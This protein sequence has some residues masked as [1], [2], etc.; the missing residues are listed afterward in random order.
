MRSWRSLRPRVVHITPLVLAS[1]AGAPAAADDDDQKLRDRKPPIIA[2]IARGP[3][4]WKLTTRLPDIGP[5]GP[6]DSTFPTRNMEL[7]SWLPLSSFPGYAGATQKSGADC[8]GYVSPSGRRYALIGLGWGTGVVEVTDPANPVILTVIPV[9]SNAYNSLW[10]DVTVIGHYAY[11][12]SD[13]VGVGIQVIDLSDVDT[14]TV[15]LVRNHSQGGHSRTHTILSNPAS[16]YLYLCGGNVAGSGMVPAATAPDPTLPTFDGPGW[17]DQYVHEAQ[18]VSYTS[19]PYAGKEIA[20][21]F[22]AGPYYTGLTTGLAIVDITNKAAPI[23]LCQ[24]AYPGLRFCHQGWI[25]EDKRYLYINDELDAPG[26]GSGSVPRFL[27]RIFDISNL[28]SPRLV[29]TFSNNLPSVD[30]NEYVKGRYLYMSNYTT[31]LRVWDLK[32]PLRPRE[33]AYIDTRPEDDATSYNG[34]WGNYPFFDDG[35][36]LVS[37]LE[38]GLFIAR[39]TLLE[40]DDPAPQPRTLEPGK[41]TPVTLRVTGKGA[42]LGTL[43]LMVTVNDGL[44]QSLPMVSLGDGL[45]G[46]ELP[47]CTCGDRVSY[48]FQ[49]VSTEGGP[50]VSPPAALNG[51][52]IRARVQTGET[53]LFADD[54][55]I[56]LGWTVQNTAVTSGAWARAVPSAT[57]GHG[58]PLADADG[59]GMCFVT[60]NGTNADVD[61]GPTVLLSPVL[62]LSAAPEAH[63]T[64]SRWLLSIQSAT[65]SLITSISGDDGQSWTTVHSV[66]PV[67][68][69]WETVGFRVADYITPTSQV[70]VRFSVSDNPDNSVTEAGIDAFVVTSAACEFCYANCDGSLVA[71]AL[72]VADFSCFLTRFA[73][74]EPYANCDGSTMAPILNVADFS[75]FLDRFASGCP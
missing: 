73:A 55:Q 50:F 45:Y 5:S 17:R 27:A 10:R 54:F 48:Y 39:L 28:S 34:A 31:G 69:G 49:A 11:S 56:N 13:N 20:F 23:E 72:N 58:A 9:P 71:P 40:L 8:W 75:C 59:S 26:S 32:E 37:D 6:M 44:P 2:P 38:R 64:Y 4:A 3:D 61:G 63:I 53:V 15:T 25:T 30:H 57:G 46:G 14:G 60:G 42:T 68:G 47:A 12:V 65:D 41:R 19:G 33:V 24:I 1:L 7:H 52:P 18:I 22:A 51:D 35:T 16:G 74:A 70:R 21:A 36:I 66:T 67:T 29:S 62:D 43:T